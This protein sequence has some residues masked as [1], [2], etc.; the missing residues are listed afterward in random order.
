MLRHIFLTEKYGDLKKEMKKD[1]ELLA[2]S[3]G[4]Q[5]QYIK[6]SD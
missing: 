2:H 1:A 5:Q 6:N 4:T 3:S